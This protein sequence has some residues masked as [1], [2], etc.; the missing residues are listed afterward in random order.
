MQELT[1][2]E[3]FYKDLAKEERETPTDPASK[4]KQS[5]YRTTDHGKL[6]KMRKKWTETMRAKCQ[7]YEERAGEC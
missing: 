1:C 5:K 6:N 7:S 3:S 4:L 2:F